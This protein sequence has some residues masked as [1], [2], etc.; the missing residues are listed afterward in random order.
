LKLTLRSTMEWS[1]ITRNIYFS[2]WKTN[3]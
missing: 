2:R 3:R 1:T